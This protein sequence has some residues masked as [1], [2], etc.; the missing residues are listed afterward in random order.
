MPAGWGGA[1]GDCE[2]ESV[3]YT[4]ECLECKK[5]GVQVEYVGETSR[6]IYERGKQH[7]GDLVG[8]VA[9]KPLWEHCK[10]DH[11]G[12]IR[13]EWF[14]MNL[15]QKHRTALQRQIKEALSIEGSMADIILNKKCE[16]N[17]SRIPR[18]RVEVGEQLDTEK[19]DERGE[20]LSDKKRL[21]K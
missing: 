9:G 14:K 6:T 8:K 20:K 13:Q 18:L 12:E 1:G 11:E 15:T 7:L 3:N 17:G 19:R 2:S 21:A 10:E 16:W 5:K 4:I